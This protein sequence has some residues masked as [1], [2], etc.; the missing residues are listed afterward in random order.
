MLVRAAAARRPGE[1]GLDEPREAQGA[2]APLAGLHAADELLG[3]GATP[4]RASREAAGAP[5]R[6]EQVGVLV[7]AV[8]RGVP[9]LPATR[10]RARQGGRLH[11]RRRERQRRRRAQASC[12]EYPVTFPSYKDPTLKIAAAFKGVRRSPPPRSTTRRASSPTRSRA[13]TPVER[14]AG[15][16]H[17]PLR[18]L[19]SGRPACSAPATR[20]RQRSRCASASSASSRALRS[21]PT[22]TGST[23]R[24][25]TSWRSRT[26]A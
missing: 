9:V 18:S 23:A 12:D 17:R 10:R 6:G 14:T 13:G 5:G 26:G 20:S 24:P 4:S 21:P 25:C 11:R 2:P 16:G 3:G 15:R 8:P 19:I 1:H 22:R 7:R